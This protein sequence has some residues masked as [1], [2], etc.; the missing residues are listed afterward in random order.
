MKKKLLIT[1]IFAVSA[2]CAC[3]ALAGC[4]GEEDADTANTQEEATVEAPTGTYVGINNDGVM[5]FKGIRY[6]TLNP[7]QRAGDVT[8]TTEDVIEAK[9]W[10]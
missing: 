1:M 3:L 10:G 2:L 8:T 6:G 4:G 5:E 9:D 7:Y